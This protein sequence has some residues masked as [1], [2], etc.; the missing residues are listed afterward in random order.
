MVADLETHAAS[1]A[2][3]DAQGKEHIL[4]RCGNE[5][6]GRSREKDLHAGDDQVAAVGAALPAADGLGGLGGI[7]LQVVVKVARLGD[8]RAARDRDGAARAQT[9]AADAR[10]ALAACGIDRAA[11]DR[12][13]AAG[14]GRGV[15]DTPMTTATELFEITADTRSPSITRGIDRAAVDRD[16]GVGAFD[17]RIIGEPAVGNQGAAAL[18]LAPDRQAAAG[19]R[20][21]AARGQGA[22]VREDD[23]HVAG[24]FDARVVRDVARDDVPAGGQGPL[25]G[26]EGVGL[27]GVGRVRHRVEVGHG[28]GGLRGGRERGGGDHQGFREVLHGSPF[29]GRRET[30]DGRRGGET[31]DGR[32]GTRRR[33]ER[34]GTRLVSRVS[35]QKWPRLS[36]CVSCQNPACETILRE[37]ARACKKFLAFGF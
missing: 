12:H 37:V 1:A 6:R 29:F 21:H 36:S 25:A 27:A 23:M 4:S 33:D 9:A 17:A 31:R 28:V 32:R 18:R 15:T 20:L 22:A 13:R 7:V 2:G 14:V 30:G 5:L 26:V 10:G 3:V 24:D 16:G 35:R 34:R 11:V 8:D 19:G